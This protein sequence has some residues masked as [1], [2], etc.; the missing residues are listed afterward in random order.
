MAYNHPVFDRLDPE[1]TTQPM[2]LR[3]LFDQFQ[4]RTSNTTSPSKTNDALM[5]AEAPNTSPTVIFHDISPGQQV[6]WDARLLEEKLKKQAEDDRKKRAEDER[7]R[8]EVE[9]PCRRLLAKHG[10]LVGKFLE[11]AERKIGVL[12]DYGDE[13]WDALPLEIHK[14]LTKIAQRE[15]SIDVSKSS[16][17]PQSYREF[18]TLAG[19]YVDLSASRLA[20]ILDSE[21][22][23]Y[24]QEH[25]TAPQN[26]RGLKGIEFEMYLAER[27][28][29]AGYSVSGTPAT[30]DQGA[31]LLATKDGIT[32][33]IQAKGYE[34]PVGNGA[35]QEI[36][37]AL[38]YYNAHEGWVA[39]NSTFTRSARDLARANK[40]R[41]LDGN[42][43]KDLFPHPLE[44]FTPS[45]IAA[46]T[47]KAAGAMSTGPSVIF[48]DISPGQ[49]LLRDA[50][51][52][53]EKLRK[54]AEEERKT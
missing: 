15:P 25:K 8:A 1:E 40:V 41:L 17:K 30:G 9:A 31:D 50:K 3:S 42:D 47:P 7:K 26:V 20:G 18:A 27:L 21:F 51:L 5:A 22:C 36:V 11:I 28:R 48:H 54:R 14:C 29:T 52:L 33:A 16:P 4:P 24:H 37:A 45:N 2:S 35:V 43:L 49:Q 12:D 34:G 32:V 53:E 23:S 19:G 6:L 44:T 13:N 46:H 10:D 38:R 39:T